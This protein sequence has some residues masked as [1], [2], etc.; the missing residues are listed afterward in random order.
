MNALNI[1]RDEARRIWALN[2]SFDYPVPHGFSV[3]V[4]AVP[5]LAGCFMITYVSKFSASSSPLAKFEF[6]VRD[7]FLFHTER[8]ICRIIQ[9]EVDD[10]LWLERR[11]AEIMVDVKSKDVEG[12]RK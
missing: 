2:K 12:R 4:M 8:R 3:D 5:F 1:I 9:K 11:A 6:F 10:I 7:Y